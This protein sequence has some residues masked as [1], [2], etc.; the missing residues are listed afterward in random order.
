[1]R[2]LQL[3]TVL[4][5]LLLIAGCASSGGSAD[6][7]TAAPSL[8]DEIVARHVEALGGRDNLRGITSRVMEGTVYVPAAGMSFPL[9]LQYERPMKMRTVVDVSAMGME[10]I[11][12]YDGETAWS[13]NPMVTRQPQKLSGAAASS[14]RAQALVDGLLFDAVT[15]DR[16][17][18]YLGEAVVRDEPAYQFRV[19]TADSSVHTVYLD[20]VTYLEVKSTGKTVDPST[21][22]L[23]DYEAYT[24]DY[25]EVNGVMAPFEIAVFMNGQEAQRVTIDEVRVNEDI[26][27]ALFAFPGGDE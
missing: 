17:L 13:L 1:M 7:A 5:V 12:A 2:T 20:A 8:A 24:S 11:S 14:V 23:A 4:A 27:D 22:G 25:R 3:L 18:E 6:D 9:T 16:R 10:I 21:G 19:T 15:A 26:D